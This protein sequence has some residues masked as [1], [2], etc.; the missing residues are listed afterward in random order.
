MIKA[1]IIIKVTEIIEEDIKRAANIIKED[2][3]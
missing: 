3:S 2:M 1:T